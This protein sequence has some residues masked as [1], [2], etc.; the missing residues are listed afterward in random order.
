M[1][2]L[3]W[4]SMQPAVLIQLIN[5]RHA[6]ALRVVERYTAGEQGAYAVADELG[7]RLVLKWGADV[8]E[9]RTAAETTEI[10]RGQGY[11][12]PEYV[13]VDEL[14]DVA[15]SVQQCLPGSPGAAVT[16]PILS[17][18]LELNALQLGRARALTA[19]WPARVANTML[20]GGDGYCLL[21]T[22]REHSA[23][24]AELL[25]ILQ[26]LVRRH[27]DVNCETGDV[28][29][30]DFQP[31]NILVEGGEVSGVVDWDATCAGDAA[32]DLATLLFYS[33]ENAEIR[34][35]LWYEVLERTVPRCVSIYLAHMILRQVEWS[36]R[37]HPG[38]ADGYMRRSQAVLRDLRRVSEKSIG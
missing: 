11:P 13:L 23:A 28:V 4:V 37:H 10:L 26:A 8:N 7:G 33:Y 2:R 6:M 36:I 1:H 22:L 32:F 5:E 17:R 3:S 14:S 31:A 38:T 24:T 9:Y 16:V 27:A 19:D 25:E 20:F 29:H 15:Y 34:E 35:R 21:D 18:L 12:A 30:Y